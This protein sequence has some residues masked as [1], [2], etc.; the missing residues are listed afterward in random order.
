MGSH[1]VEPVKGRMVRLG[2]G[3]GSG[4]KELGRGDET[5]RGDRGGGNGGSY[6]YETLEVSKGGLVVFHGNL[7][8]RSGRNVSGKGRVAYSF[9]VIDGRCECPDD[10]YIK[11]VGGE[12]ERL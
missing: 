12:F 11:P 9:T 5:V 8:H 4:F 6:K 10:T 2:K 3:G 1:L 7:M